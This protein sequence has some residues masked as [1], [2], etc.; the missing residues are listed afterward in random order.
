MNMMPTMYPIQGYNAMPQANSVPQ[1]M[2][3]PTVPAYGPM[4]QQMGYPAMQAMPYTTSL[5]GYNAP[6]VGTTMGYPTA[7]QMTG[8]PAS[9]PPGYAPHP[10]SGGVKQQHMATFFNFMQNMFSM[11]MKTMGDTYKPSAPYTQPPAQAYAPS[12]TKPPMAPAISPAYKQAPSMMA[13]T[14]GAQAPVAASSGGGGMESAILN[15]INSYRQSQGLQ[16]LVADPGLMQAARGRSQDQARKGV[17]SH[18]G[19]EQSVK[20]LGLSG[21]AENVAMNKGHKDPAS[22]SVQGWLNSPGH[23]KNIVGNY[24]K[25]GIAVEQAPDGSYYYTQLFGK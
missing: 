17:M 22:Q 11:F 7:P 12:Y 21:T 4:P 16:P 14:T 3:Y 19:F 9:M 10:S 18:D 23:H 2:A 13:P 1:Q 5:P 6:A 8:Y 24:T 25:T 20:H 15:Q